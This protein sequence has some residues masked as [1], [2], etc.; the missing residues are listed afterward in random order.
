MSITEGDYCNAGEAGGVL[1]RGPFKIRD[2]AA[3]L[4]TADGRYLMQLRDDVPQLRVAGHWGL[5]GGGVEPGETHREAL[6]RELVEEL[7]FRPRTAHWFTECAFVLPQIGVA[8]T[9]KVFFVVPIEEADVAR[10][11]QHEGAGRRLFTLEEF[12]AEPR[13]VPW[14]LCAVLMHARRETVFRWPTTR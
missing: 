9:E 5:F 11:V 14:D 3:L 6:A 7:E 13:V 1:A 12:L 4:V 2:V 8:A 10:M